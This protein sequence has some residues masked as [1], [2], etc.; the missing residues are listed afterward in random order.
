MADGSLKSDT[1]PTIP[2]RLD[3]SNDVYAKIH[4]RLYAQHS[5]IFQVISVAET[6]MG[7]IAARD[8]NGDD[9]QLTAYFGI[10]TLMNDTLTDIAEEI[11]PGSILDREPSDRER[12]EAGAIERR[13]RCRP[14]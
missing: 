2:P 10:L 11:E 12:T 7:S 4:E 1:S 14:Y 3:V 5:R 6:L 9:D 13:M 8:E